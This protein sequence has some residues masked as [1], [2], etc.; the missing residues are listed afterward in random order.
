MSS[1]VEKTLQIAL[2]QFQLGVEEQPKGSNSGPQVN[3][4]L[5]SVGLGAGYSWCMA[6]VYWCVLRAAKELNLR[7]PLYKTGGVLKMWNECPNL[8]ISTPVVGSIFIMS[9][10]KGMGHTGFVESF[11]ERFIYTIEGNTNAMGSREGYQVAK[12]KRLRSSIKGYLKFS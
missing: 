5:K 3:E 12:R 4:Y 7:H 11:D 9:L 2:S 8:R 10:G 6:F 1:L